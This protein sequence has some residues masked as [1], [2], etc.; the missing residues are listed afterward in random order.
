ML[1]YVFLIN[2]EFFSMLFFLYLHHLDN[3]EMIYVIF[4]HLQQLYHEV[5]NLVNYISIKVRKNEIK[6]RIK[7]GHIQ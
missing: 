2:Q 1:W 3:F 7:K 5:Q 6:K 4:S